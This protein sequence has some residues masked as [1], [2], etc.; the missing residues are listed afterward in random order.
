[1]QLWCCCVTC[2]CL[3]WRY[4]CP[5]V[6]RA[7]P[8]CRRRPGTELRQLS[9]EFLSRSGRWLSGCVLTEGSGRQ[10]SSVMKTKTVYKSL[11]KADSSQE[12]APYLRTHRALRRRQSA[13]ACCCRKP[14]GIACLCLRACRSDEYLACGALGWNAMVRQSGRSGETSLAALIRLNLQPN[15]RGKAWKAWEQGGAKGA[16]VMY[17]CWNTR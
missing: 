6:G 8:P 15:G 10:R 14:R 3:S 16:Q 1:M 4:L 9:A 5:E 7:R 12:D 2:C 17:T 11:F 13:P